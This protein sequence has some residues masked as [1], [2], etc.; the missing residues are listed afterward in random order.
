M[1]EV[2]HKKRFFFQYCLKALSK[3]E[4]FLYFPIYIPKVLRK[5]WLVLS[6]WSQFLSSSDVINNIK[7]YQEENFH[8]VRKAEV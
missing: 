8:Q 1:P 4:H 2:I 5:K 6:D 7:R 3:Y